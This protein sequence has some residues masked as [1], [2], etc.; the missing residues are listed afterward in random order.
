[1]IISD[2]LDA[3]CGAVE[4]AAMERAI[5]DVDEA[6]LNQYEMRRRHREVSY[7]WATSYLLIS[8]HTSH[9]RQ[10]AGFLS[11]IPR[12]QTPTTLPT[13]QNRSESKRLAFNGHSGGC[14]KTFVGL[15]GCQGLRNS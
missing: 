1:M 4:K 13:F 7:L 8:N 3:A 14:M 15:A 11:G 5:V 6:F 2:N 12:P 9:F 10:E